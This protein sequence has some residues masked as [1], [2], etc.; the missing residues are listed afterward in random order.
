MLAFRKQKR[1]PLAI[2]SALTLRTATGAAL[3]TFPDGVVDS[4]RHM[5]TSLMYKGALPARIS[6]VAALREEG[7]TYTTL[8]LATTLA[9]DL[10]VRVCV[11]E[12]NW[13]SPVIKTQPLQDMDQAPATSRKSRRAKP[14]QSEIQLAVATTAHLP[15]AAGPAGLAAVLMEYMSLDEALVQ[16]A[17]P[18]LALLPAGDLTLAQRPAMARSD[19]LKACINQLSRRF[20]HIVLDIPAILAT[21]DAIA[22]ASLGTSCCIVVRQGVTPVSSVRRALDDVKHLPM[23]GVILNQANTK[24]PRWVRALVP[25]E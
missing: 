9:Y 8:A 11:V 2:N 7:V 12:L 14:K 3:Y 13:W 18:N 1:S 5:A 4:M 21:S 22:L 15:A 16:T 25:Q 6:M 23:L 17:M 20:D 24:L 10:A 19:A